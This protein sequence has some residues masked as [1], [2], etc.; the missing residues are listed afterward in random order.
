MQ[1]LFFKKTTEILFGQPEMSLDRAALRRQFQSSQNVTKS[2]SFPAKKRLSIMRFSNHRTFA[3]VWA[4]KNE[5]R[6]SFEP[7]WSP[8]NG[9]S[10]EISHSDC[11]KWSEHSR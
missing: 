3:F 10:A 4:R 2:R 5:P 11:S 1:E 8:R 7:K 9:N 6:A